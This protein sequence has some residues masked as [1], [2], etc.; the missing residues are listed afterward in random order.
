MLVVSNIIIRFTY[1]FV[2]WFSWLGSSNGL[3]QES[4]PIVDVPFFNKKVYTRH[5]NMNF[6]SVEIYKCPYPGTE[7]NKS[8]TEL[9]EILNVWK[10]YLVERSFQDL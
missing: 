1:R 5:V 3:L 8:I 4:E 9:K 2:D 10:Q 6:V 7:A